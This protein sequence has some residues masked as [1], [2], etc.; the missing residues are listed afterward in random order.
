[1]PL[2]Y[3]VLFGFFLSQK[4]VIS[5]TLFPFRTYLSI[6]S[7]LC[8]LVPFQFLTSFFKCTIQNW[9][10]LTCCHCQTRTKNYLHRADGTLVNTSCSCRA[11][12]SQQLV[13]GDLVIH[14]SCQTLFC[15]SAASL[16]FC[17]VFFACELESVILN[18]SLKVLPRFYLGFCGYIEVIL[19][20]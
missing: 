6:T 3:H 10:W 17:Y 14:A 19:Q 5:F 8:A 11:F 1:M 13:A 20:C 12:A 15:S 4:S 18:F 7:C 16:L 2:G 9:M